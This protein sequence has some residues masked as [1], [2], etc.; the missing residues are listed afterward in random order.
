MGII[1]KQG[2]SIYLLP[3]VSCALLLLPAHIQSQLF[4][5]TSQLH[6]DFYFAQ[7]I[8]G[9]LSHLS[10]QH[11]FGNLIG[12]IVFQQIYGQCISGKQWIV[13]TLLLM[14]LISITLQIISIELVWYAGISST[15]IGLTC[16][17]ALVDKKHDWK[18][19]TA[20]ITAISL[21]SVLQ[22]MDGEIAQGL[23]DVPVA[24]YSH[25][26]AI[27]GGIVIAL[28]KRAFNTINFKN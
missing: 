10:W 20:I 12:L 18:L 4:L 26:I 17:C 6:P 21:Y 11:F 22:M 28:S 25:I 1:K 2:G 7:W 8:T 16:Y 3:S 9:H 24:S 5:Y 13:P 23:G 15:I 27:I 19:N 14:L